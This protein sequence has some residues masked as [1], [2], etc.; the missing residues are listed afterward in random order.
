[1]NKRITKLKPGVALNLSIAKVG[2]EAI[3]IATDGGLK[4]IKSGKR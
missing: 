3:L 2:A 4:K 1:M